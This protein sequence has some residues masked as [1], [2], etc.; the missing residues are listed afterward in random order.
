M[1]EESTSP[2]PPRIPF[3]ALPMGTVIAG[4]FTLE[5]VAG[6]GGMG[7]VY[8]AQDAH[9]GQP[10]ALKLLHTFTA[11]E[12]FHRFNRESVLLTELSHPAIVSHVEHGVSEGGEPFLAMEWLEGMELSHRL[13][14]Q[15]LSLSESLALVHRIA[16][17]L[18]QAHRRGIVHRDIKPSNLFLRGGRPEDVVLLDFGLARTVEPSLVAV[19]GSET[20]VGTPGYMAPEQA[21]SQ[22][23]LL[24]SADIFSL[25]CVL[26][27]CLTGKPPFAA[28]HFAAVLAKILFAE[29]APLRTLR[30]ELPFSLQ[31][32]VDRMLVKDPRKRLPDADSLLEALAALETGPER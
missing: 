32:L 17:G 3:G 9:T 5:S 30:A 18:A 24:P 13:A 2:S 6:R 1:E 10:V 20:V 19:T 7:F 29:P 14:L 15:P 4:R 27:Q 21:S 12:A 23:D 31:R 16:E 28:P 22:P 11:P 25:G 26:Y 8:R